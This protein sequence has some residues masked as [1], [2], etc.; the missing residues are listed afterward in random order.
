MSR[1]SAAADTAIDAVR[2]PPLTGRYHL[3]DHP[4]QEMA[5]QGVIV[6]D[7]H[8]CFK[9]LFR[10]CR[11]LNDMMCFESKPSYLWRLCYKSTLEAHPSVQRNLKCLWISYSSLG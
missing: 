7:N 4:N 11:W 9:W 6:V 5:G 3:L 1:P 10:L 2:V 8:S